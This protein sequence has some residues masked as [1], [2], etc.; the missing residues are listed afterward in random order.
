MCFIILSPYPQFFFLFWTSWVDFR[1]YALYPLIHSIHF[2]RARTF[3]YRT[4]VQFTN[5]GKSTLTTL[6][7]NVCQH[8]DFIRGSND[9]LIGISSLQNRPIWNRTLHVVVSSCSP[10][11]SLQASCFKKAT[12]ACCFVSLSDSSSA[13]PAGIESKWYHQKDHVHLPILVA[14]PLVTQLRRYPVSPVYSH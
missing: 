9:I 10:T 2:L 4:S 11:P 6:F 3:S 13:L 12:W 1:H 8:C 5:S 7:H 14:W